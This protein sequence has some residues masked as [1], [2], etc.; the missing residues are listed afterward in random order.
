MT[1]ACRSGGTSSRGSTATT[2]TAS[3]PPDG[4]RPRHH[5]PEDSPIANSPDLLP[6][7]AGRVVV[8]RN[9]RDAEAI[10]KAIGTASRH[11]PL[12][13]HF[14]HAPDTPSGG[15]RLERRAFL[16]GALHAERWRGFVF[17]VFVA[18]K[19]LR[20]LFEDDDTSD[21]QPVVV[22]KVRKILSFLEAMEEVEELQQ[23]PNWRAHQLPRC[24]RTVLPWYPCT[25]EAQTRSM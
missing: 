20:R 12:P 1:R 17:G 24:H 4:R 2:P 14:E 23:F 21:F 25:V 6:A 5:P 7:R 9:H 8:G 10:R 13:V 3:A 15:E 11:Y 18:H 19:G 16:D 22:E